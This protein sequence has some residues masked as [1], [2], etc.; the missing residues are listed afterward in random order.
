MKKLTLAAA[1]L[2]LVSCNSIANVDY[3]IMGTLRQSSGDP[4]KWCW[5]NDKQH[6]TIGVKKVCAKAKGDTLTFQYDKKHAQVLT[7]IVGPDETFASEGYIFG[8]S[9]GLGK[10]IIKGSA[11]G[12]PIN[13]DDYHVRGNIW[14]YGKMR[15][16][17]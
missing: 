2:M 3:E 4:S 10:S 16:F 12:S 5:I 17:E 7:L 6:R 14:V 13:F 11:Y 1:A 15:S 8:A 9:V